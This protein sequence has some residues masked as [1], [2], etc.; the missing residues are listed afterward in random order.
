MLIILQIFTLIKQKLAKS[1]QVVRD[2]T[3]APLP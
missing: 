1:A 2:Q 3:L